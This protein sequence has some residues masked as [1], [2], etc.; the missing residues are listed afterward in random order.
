VLIVEDHEATAYLINRAFQARSEQVNW[1]LCFAKDGE[2]ALECLFKRG[3]H[4]E[5]TL[6]DFVLL[7]WNLPK[8]SGED[9][10]R[11]LRSTEELKAL[12]VIVSSSSDAD[13]DVRAAYNAQANGYVPKPSNL[14]AIS[15]VIESIEISGCILPGFLQR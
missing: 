14:D 3:V 15:S 12:P 1:D 2:E 8:V 10:L 7:D 6:P 4:A 9:V 13:H 11:M 5:A